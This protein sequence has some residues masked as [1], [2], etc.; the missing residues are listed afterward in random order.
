VP[1]GCERFSFGPYGA[2]RAR[3]PAAGAHSVE[4][5]TLCDFN[6][7]SCR[8]RIVV[9]AGR[10]IL[11]QTGL[12]HDPPER[13]RLRLTAAATGH[14]TVTIVVEGDDLDTEADPPVRYAYRA[15]WRLGCAGAPRRDVC[16]IGG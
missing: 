9:R 11:G 3:P 4:I 16:R 14:R 10:R 5:P 1:V 8:R 6:Y 13:V 2:M 15:S 12:A 7:T